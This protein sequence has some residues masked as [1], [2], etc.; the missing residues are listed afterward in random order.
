MYRDN[1][2]K[3]VSIMSTSD[4]KN[5][6]PIELYDSISKQA[7]L[8]RDDWIE[9]LVSLNHKYP[10]KIYDYNKHKSV[11]IVNK[12]KYIK[13]LKKSKSESF[14]HYA[15]G[16]FLKLYSTFIKNSMKKD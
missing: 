15:I 9:V 13:F 1:Y 8:K 7:N 3:I 5:T 11:K 2:L 6:K 12:M 4:L 14:K 16:Y 10:F